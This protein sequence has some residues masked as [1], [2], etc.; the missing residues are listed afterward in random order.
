MSLCLTTIISI[1][2]NVE[3]RVTEAQEEVKASDL[4]VIILDIQCTDSMLQKIEDN[5]NI[6]HVSVLKTITQQLQINDI[7]INSSTFFAEYDPEK[8]PYRIYN[9]DGLSFQ[10]EPQ[11]LKVGEIYVPI[12]FQRL[13][14]C[15]IGDIAY[16]SSGDT[17]RDFIVKG[18]F[19]D[20]FI[21]SEVIGIKLAQMNKEDFIHLYSQ[22]SQKEEEIKE[23]KD[24]IA[25][26]N[27][28]NL[29]QTSD[30]SLTMSELKKEV[31]ETSAIID[32]S[33]LSISKEQSKTYTLMFMQI[34]SGIM[35][36]FL[37]VLFIVILI[38]MGYSI[39]TG[40]EINYSNLGI[41]KAIGYPKRKLQIVFVLEYVLAELL[42]IVIGMV[43]SIPAIYY[44]NRI[45]VSM[46]GLLSPVRLAVGSCLFILIIVVLISA[47]YIF[48]KTKGITKISP[49]R[50]ISGGRENIY[51]HS[52][53]EIPVEGRG[54]G[55]RIVLRQLTSNIKQY[56]SS[57][58]IV[59]ILVFFII[60]ITVLSH[61]MDSKTISQ[62]FGEVY[63]DVGVIYHQEDKESEEDKALLQERV[64]ELI[65]ELSPIVTSFQIG[66]NYF[67]VNGE[68]YHGSI[69]SDPT[70]MKSILKGRVPTYDNEIVIT[71]I[72]ADEMGL[73]MGDTIIVGNE[74]IEDEYIISGIYQSTSDLGRTIAM[75]FE[76]AQKIIPD[77]KISSVEYII[78][79][80][81]KSA[82]ITETLKERYEGKIEVKDINA[83]EGSG[84]T[85]R[86]VL[87][88]LNILIY[89]ISILVSFVVIIIVC[90]KVFLKER[91]DYGIYKSLGFTSRSLRI[92]FA[93][94]F[95]MVAFL[96]SV[97]GVLLNIS[98][99]NFIMSALLSNFGI[100]NFRSEYSLTNF[101]SPILVLIACFFVFSYLI[102][103]K[104]KSV[105]TKSL[106]NDN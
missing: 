77:Y 8:H 28:V 72:V 40:I 51:F 47:L 1:N 26:F 7:T 59:A 89:T 71:E 101:L 22:R 34:I 78:S 14:D 65:S 79:D 76:A 54:L 104:I 61:S 33:L 83:L 86:S 56:I 84:S 68:E 44:L 70:V 95:A 82:E 73:Q 48:T 69:Y 20:P 3:K 91:M 35:L 93:L 55:I 11:D 98:L 85:V 75:S 90:G 52:R 18:F 60:T 16:F 62:R 67:T 17:R 12:S 92:Q 66:N 96:G 38:I 4:T 99:N 23:K 24:N 80:S 27:F 9:E 10:K 15:K 64:E 63:S 6:D 37:I 5:H 36:A 97:L 50:A 103:H 31:N 102:S 49:I 43:G 105:D 106:F 88:S 74:D 94:R 13:Y 45:F 81:S 2:Y 19:E 100:T 30:S 58:L 21:G 41:L 32:Y 46:T 25:G 87:K 57:A 42:G 29:Y 53:L 39:S